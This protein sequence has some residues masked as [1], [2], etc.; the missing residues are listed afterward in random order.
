MSPLEDDVT[1]SETLAEEDKTQR[2]LDPFVLDPPRKSRGA[3]WTSVATTRRWRSEPMVKQ[4]KDRQDKLLGRSKG[5]CGNGNSG[6][7]I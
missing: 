3:N 1:A 6:P 5:N 2:E 4:G 7:S